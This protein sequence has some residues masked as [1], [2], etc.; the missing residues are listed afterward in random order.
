MQQNFTSNNC[1]EPKNEGNV[2]MGDA[3]SRDWDQPP[4]GDSHVYN[5]VEVAER[6]KAHIGSKYGGAH[7]IMADIKAVGVYTVLFRNRKI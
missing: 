2:H 3:F 4:I 1:T 6:G 5:G 7:T